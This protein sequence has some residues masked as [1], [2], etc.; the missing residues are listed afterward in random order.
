LGVTLLER[1][2]RNVRLTPA[3]KALL[4]EGR[5]ALAQA[6]R[7]ISV[8]RAA[9][10]E[11]LTVGFYGSAGHGL[12]PAV[13]AAFKEGH[14]RIQVVVREVPFGSLDEIYDGKVDLALTRL[15]PGQTELDVEV[16]TEEP[17]VLVLAS[18][19]PLAGRETLRF[20]ELVDEAFIVNPMTPHG[21]A[22][23][24]WLEEQRRHGLPGRVVAKT[25]SL[26]EILTLVAAS[27]GVSLVPETV[28]LNER[29]PDISYVP[30]I[31][32]EP[33]VV[34]LVWDSKRCSPTVQEFVSVAREV[35]D[36]AAPEGASL[37]ASPP[38]GPGALGATGTDARSI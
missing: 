14:P 25:R 24:R 29:R 38:G 30:V 31:D 20:A 12:L 33:A 16:L 10:G 23:A 35:G 22:P 18:S 3:G 13:L 37:E 34:S 2:S 15:R 4:R 27:R 1:N 26:Q 9:G 19:H 11:L 17:R 21:D 28:A 32:A 36:R 8:T 7:A 5:R 6:E